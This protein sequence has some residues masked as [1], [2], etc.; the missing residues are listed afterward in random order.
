MYYHI[1]I[2]ELDGP[3]GFLLDFFSQFASKLCDTYFG[4]CG[5][6]LA[7]IPFISVENAVNLPFFLVYG[8]LKPQKSRD[9]K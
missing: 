2:S 1:I 4:P 5:K 9:P 3:A 6:K 8:R 7:D